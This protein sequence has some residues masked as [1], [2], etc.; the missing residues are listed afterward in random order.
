[1]SNVESRNDTDCLRAFVAR[2]MTI[3]EEWPAELRVF[4]EKLTP[5]DFGFWA[6]GF[7]TASSPATAI[8]GCEMVKFLKKQF[9]DLG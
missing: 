8:S 6:H 4:A 5:R 3:R 2:I 7:A 9:M 1:M